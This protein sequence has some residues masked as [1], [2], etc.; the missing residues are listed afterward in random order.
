[1]KQLPWG[2]IQ[3]NLH[4]MIN[5]GRLSD[6]AFRLLFSVICLTAGTGTR[7]TGCSADDILW[8]ARVDR[9]ALDEAISRGVLVLTEQGTVALTDL[10][11]PQETRDLWGHESTNPATERVRR[12]RAT[13]AA[14][15]AAMQA[16]PQLP[17]LLVE[18]TT[19]APEPSQPPIPAAKPQ[20]TAPLKLVDSTPAPTPKAETTLAS[21]AQAT[22]IFPESLTPATKKSIQ[23]ILSASGVTHEQ[24][25][26]IV[27]EIAGNIEEGK[28]I[29]TPP[30]WARMA[31]GKI[32]AGNFF[33]EYAHAVAERREMA[34]K[35]VQ[36]QRE[37]VKESP[38][39]SLEEV[40]SAIMSNPD[41]VMRRFL[42]ERLDSIGKVRQ[43]A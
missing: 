26:I 27:D 25:Q 32:L 3:S 16:M 13:K 23:K 35:A 22:L 5:V 33:P 9:P 34:A 18:V 11:L 39:I 21:A 6:T 1:M 28:E 15:R 4:R 17:G 20:E 2:K 19:S 10:V 14:E 12:H 7:D 36:R 43:A 37:L 30:G 8:D 38:A 31:A 24:A 40:R 29:R 41:P 42:L